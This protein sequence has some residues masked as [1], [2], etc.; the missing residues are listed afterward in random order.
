MKDNKGV[1][2][3]HCCVLHGCKYGDDN[4]PV[5]NE[6]IVQ[7]CI[8]ESCDYDG[9][10]TVKEAQATNAMNTAKTSYH[11]F[12]DITVLCWDCECGAFYPVFSEGIKVKY[13]VTCPICGNKAGFEQNEN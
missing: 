12:S 4:C 9:I 7:T 11:T 6:E 2:Q 8:C 1:H 13:I 10:K 3:T 5:E